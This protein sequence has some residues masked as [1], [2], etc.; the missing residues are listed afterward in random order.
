M[1][2]NH[3]CEER[4]SLDGHA[5]LLLRCHFDP[6]GSLAREPR[7]RRPRWAPPRRI[8]GMARGLGTGRRIGMIGL[9]LS[10]WDIWMRIPPRQRRQ[11]VEQARRHG[12]RLAR[13]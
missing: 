5:L 1:L 8:V 12:P 10:A 13:E 6:R 9:A 4:W 3:L 2:L 7:R 11:L